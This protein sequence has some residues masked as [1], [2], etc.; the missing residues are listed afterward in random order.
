[1]RYGRILGWAIAL[2]FCSIAVAADPVDINEADARAIAQAMNGVGMSKAEAIIAFREE[3]GPF[4]SVDELVRV[5]G[6][7]PATI[8]NNREAVTVRLSSE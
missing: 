7:G 4:A 2:M 1:M 3:N 8:E 6:I 5:K